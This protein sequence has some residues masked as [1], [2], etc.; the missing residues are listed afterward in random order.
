MENSVLEILVKII[1]KASGGLTNISKSFTNL[2]SSANNVNKKLAPLNDAV[3]AGLKLAT[4]VGIAAIGGLTAAI[5]T[6][7][8]AA[9]DMDQKVA[10]IA[11]VMNESKSAIE[12]L[13]NLITNLG[14][15]PKLKVTATE[16]AGAIEMLAKN[17]L[18]MGQILEGAARNTIL[19]SNA[20]GADMSTAADIAT[21]AMA[22]FNIKAEDMKRAVDGITGVTVNSKFGIND[23]ALALGT[24]AKGAIAAG[25]QFDQF[26]QALTATA[27]NFTS[28]MTAGTSLTAMFLGLAPRTNKATELMQELGIITEDGKNRFFDLNGQVRSNAE[29]SAVLQ[30]TLGKLAPEQRL[31]AVNTIFGRDAMAAVNG[32]I[33]TTD[34]SWKDYTAS[35]AK[36]DAEQQAATRMDTLTGSLEI[37]GGIFE[38]LQLK[39]GDKFLPIFKNLV[40]RISEFLAS[41]AEQ[42][43]EWAGTLADK[44]GNLIEQYLPVFLDLIES[45]IAQGPALAT[46][47]SGIV[48]QIGKFI[49]KVIEVATPIANWLLQADNLK[50]VLGVLASL[51]A[52]NF[53]ASMV[54]LVAGIVSA[55]GAVGGFLLALN[56]VTLVIGAIVLAIIGLYKAWQS[57]FWGIRDITSSVW[58][59]L[60]GWFNNISSW[61]SDFPN[62][63]SNFGT[64]LFQKAQW[65]MDQLKNGISLARDSVVSGFNVVMDAINGASNGRFDSLKTSL[66]EAGKAALNRIG[67]GFQNAKNSVQA[68]FEQVANDVK[69]HGYSYAAGAM[70]GRFYEG[71]KNAIIRFS[72]GFT[73]NSGNASKDMENILRAVITS[74]D[75]NINGFKDHVYDPA[76]QIV[77]R[78]RDG[79]RDVN[80]AD[81][82]IWK[83]NNVRDNFN[84]LADSF[85]N[86]FY[87]G[88]KSLSQRIKDGLG[89]INIGENLQWRFQDIITAFNNWVGDFSRHVWEPMKDIGRRIMD[90]LGE[91]LRNSLGSVLNPLQDIANQL[92]QWMK[93]RLGIHSP[94]VVFMEIGKNI[95]LGMKEGIQRNFST[96]LDAMMQAGNNLVTAMSDLPNKVVQGTVA[97]SGD[98]MNNNVSY[99]NTKIFNVG[100]QNSTTRGLDTNQQTK[101]LLNQL[102]AQYG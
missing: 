9:A 74:F 18:S 42:I 50:L 93:D 31:L 22:L 94:S 64:T 20:T 6:S 79:F 4:G 81:D 58:E 14:L 101:S 17:G 95:M 16:A 48:V 88:A 89:E 68:A 69:E 87:E 85:R 82:F 5:I 11:A 21:D 86:H 72:Q 52:I 76:K 47:L 70:A 37:L 35:L 75:I 10:D 63:L 15:D 60:K 13:K 41:H 97:N 67:E 3:G 77:E 30:D 61:F 8:R 91:G 80:I 99:N 51:I 62:K 46:Q 45:W 43:V 7:T 19:L 25:I 53:V 2:E 40:D 102:V 73:E 56:P 33:N 26:N 65:V 44:I 78:I 29:I 98:T 27:S 83:L 23:Y 38:T 55:V 49:E 1:D 100:L 24:G 28:G 84:L 66:F 36:V 90:G 96:P 32:M 54:S 12:P 71:A 57:N 39:I 34:T 92:P 59:A